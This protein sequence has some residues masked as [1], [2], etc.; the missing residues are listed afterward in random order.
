[1]TVSTKISAWDR[2]RQLS[3]RPGAA[4]SVDI[5]EEASNPMVQTL[6]P[7][8]GSA[9][10]RPYVVAHLAQ[11]LDGRIALASGE[12]QWI[13]GSED[14]V[15]THRL[16]ALVDAVLVGASTAT[17]D[18]PQLTVRHVD[19]DQPTRVVI[20]PNGRVPD[21]SRLFTDGMAPTLVVGPSAPGQAECLGSFTSGDGVDLADVLAALGDRGVRRLLV[22][23]GGVTVSR[24]LAAGLV[25]RLHL[26]VSP[27]LL[28][29]GRPSL[30]VALGALDQCPRPRVRTTLLG[31]DT[32]YDLDFRG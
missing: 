15:H 4:S 32:L 1:V 9:V 22:E 16:R 30:D 2:L 6:L 25:D 26:V 11:S 28:G 13:S 10:G 29:Q 19:G 23:G 20:D 18:D 27:V 24:F 21:D 7:V 31:A 17:H 12:S 5:R 14:V 8:L 3:D